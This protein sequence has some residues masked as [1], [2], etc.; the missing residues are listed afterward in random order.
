MRRIRPHPE[1]FKRFSG[2]AKPSAAFRVF[3]LD[4]TSAGVYFCQVAC[5]FIFIQRWTPDL[6]GEPMGEDSLNGSAVPSELS[7][8][9]VIRK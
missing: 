9:Q 6:P 3:D 8:E 2:R 1:R 5:Y 4:K 7:S